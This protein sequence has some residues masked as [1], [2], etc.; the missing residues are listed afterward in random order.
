VGRC[1]ISDQVW[2]TWQTLTTPHGILRRFFLHAIPCYGGC[3]RETFGSAG[4]WRVFRFFQSARSCHPFVWKTE[5][6]SSSTS[7]NE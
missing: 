5:D 7:A 1:K 6:G 2:K 4:I 3:A